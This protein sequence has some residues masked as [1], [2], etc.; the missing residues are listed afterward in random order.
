MTTELDWLIRKAEM[1]DLEDVKKIADCHKQEL[2]F[3]LKPILARSIAQGELFVAV[4]NKGII[5]FIQY[6]HRRDLQ[7]TLHNIVVESRYRK[8]GI[9][10]RLVEFLEKES[11]SKKQTI[12]QLKCPENLPA[13]I[14]YEHIGYK[15]VAVERGKSRQLNIWRK[16]LVNFSNKSVSEE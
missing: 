2:G 11:C 9:G 1:A 5:G 8:S 15:K 12:I 6:H 10:Q 3:V 13:N 4:K 7:T 14:F 16:V